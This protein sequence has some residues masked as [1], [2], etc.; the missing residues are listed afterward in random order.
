MCDTRPH[1]AHSRVTTTED[2]AHRKAASPVPVR[3]IGGRK[4][5]LD[6]TRYYDWEKDGRCVDF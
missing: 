5:G 2:L 1:D 4:K 6:P 3:E